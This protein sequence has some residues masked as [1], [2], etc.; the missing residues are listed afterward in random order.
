M[1]EYDQ[2]PK[3]DGSAE[4]AD[5]AHRFRVAAAH[6]A[7]IAAAMLLARPGLPIASLPPGNVAVIWLPAGVALAGMLLLGPR[8]LFAIFTASFATNAIFLLQDSLGCD[9]FSGQL[10]NCGLWNIGLWSVALALPDTVQAALA[11]QL[12]RRSGFQEPFST[13]RGVIHFLCCVAL[14]PCLATSWLGPAMLHLGGLTTSLGLTQLAQH[15]LIAVLGNTLGI[16]LVVPLYFAFR[17][18]E[19]DA[20]DLTKPLYTVAA[21]LLI[22]GLCWLAFLHLP[23]A[24]F[25][26]MPLLLFFAFCSGLRGLSVALLIV[27]LSSEAA[28]DMGYGPFVDSSPAMAYTSLAT[29]LL[30]LLPPFHYIQAVMRELRAH[31]QGLAQK[32][33]ARTRELEVA[34]KRL[35]EIANTDELTGVRTRRRLLEIAEREATR[36]RRYLRPLSLLA[37]DIDHFKRVNDSHGHAVGDEVLRELTKRIESRLRSGDRLGRMGGEEFE[38]LLPE[39]GLAEA[40]QTAEKLRSCVAT[41]DL[42]T[43]VGGLRITVS[44][45]VATLRPDEGLDQALLRADKALYKAKQAGRNR[46]VALE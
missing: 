43:S 12:L 45:G 6:L 8:A 36:S 30:C 14:L 18:T 35:R 17:H 3:P 10:W 16:C 20:Q 31:R 13:G 24:R 22:A 46:V 34:N 1:R 2:N 29:F 7:L 27:G 37:L 19:P 5:G 38:V 15:A 25:L 21:L 11:Y 9:L 44:F 23:Q 39:T 4:H 42:P 28:T 41:Q 33:H 26:L 40:V 32:N